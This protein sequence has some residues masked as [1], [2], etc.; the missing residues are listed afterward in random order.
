[1]AWNQPGNNGQ[2]R[3]PWGSSKPGGNSGGNKGGREQ[4]P[5]DLDDIFRKLSKKLGGIG[6]GKG[7]GSSQEPRGHLGGR[8]VGIVAAAAVILWAVTGFYTIKEAERGVVTRFGK[9]SHLVEPG[10]NWKP[11]FIDEVVPVNVEAVR[12]LAASGVMLTS[13]ENVVRVEMNV[14]YRV[15]DPQRYLFSVANA[16]DS[17]RQ[18]TDSAL[19]GVIGK[20]TMD[21]ILTEGRTVIRSDTQR[22]LEE[23][24][25]PYN[26]GITLLDVNFQAA[27]P[28]EE[29]KAA[30][31]DAIAARENEQQ[32]I[33]EAEAYTNEVQP[34]ANG[35]AQRILEEARAYK[36]QTVLEAQG[37]VARFA[38]ILPEYKAAP[39]ITRE[40]LYIETMEKVLSHTRK[41]LVN[42][43]GGNLMVLPLDQMLKGGSAP[44]ASDDNNSGNPLLRLPPVSGSGN[45]GASNSAS[46]GRGDIMDQRRANAQR[47]DYQREGS[48]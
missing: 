15:T 5:P 7:G 3:D 16:D 24:I 23:T 42:D 19:R 29:V 2:D 22:E 38:K 39:E 9:F 40:R 45:S 41:V 18:A 34:R 47:N 1:M 8:V 17:L 14:Q 32:Y 26:M 33:R 25:R 44:A 27:R 13:D 31:D 11:T 48:E 37:E 30:F 10:L 43:K 20:Y 4:G 21:R 6:G 35:Q 12:E 36:T 46:S 28:P